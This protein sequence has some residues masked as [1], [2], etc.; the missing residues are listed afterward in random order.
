MQLKVPR[1]VWLCSFALAGLAVLLVAATSA[2]AN[3]H[4]KSAGKEL[5]VLLPHIAPTLDGDGPGSNDPG[6]W[7]MF[8]NVY[9]RLVGYPTQ[10]VGKVIVPNYK[11][12]PLQFAPELAQSY[13]K[14]GLNWTFHLRKGV[15][16]CAGNELTTDDVVYTFARGKSVSGTA[17]IAWFMLNVSGVMALDP[18]LPKAPAAAKLLKGEITKVDNYTFTVKQLGP[19][20]LFPRLLE[21][22]GM[23]IYDSKEIKKHAT[24]ADPWSHKF[25][26]NVGAAGFGP[27]CVTRWAKGSEFELTANPKWTPQPQFT[28]AIIRQVPV[29]SNRISAIRSGS[30]DIVT[31]LSPTEYQSLRSASNVDVLSRF[32][33]Q[34]VW[35]FMNYK[36]APWNLPKNALLRQAV[37]LAMPYNDI[38]AQDYKGRARRWNGALPST[39]YGYKPFALY[40]T[41]LA[42][43]KA[44]LAKA[45]FPGGKGLEKYSE[46]LKLLYPA[47]RSALSEPVAN[48][49]RTALAKIGIPITLNPIPQ[50]E[51]SD[52]ELTKRDMPM[53]LID[54]SAPFGPDIGY[55]AQLYFVSV[56]KGGLLNGSN[57]SN[58]TFDTDYYKSQQMTGAARLTALGKLQGILMNNLPIVPIAEF[59][60]QIVV[61]KGLTGWLATTDNGV[62]LY[63]FTAPN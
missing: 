39:Y 6:M 34:A 26:G 48:R 15:I 47:E 13:S 57:Y 36:Y 45:G 7:M 53:A 50:T 2:G 37:A 5:V 27:Y 11:I 44:L 32:N 56:A 33:N 21:I 43:A 4:A 31:D 54:Y 22:F 59:E 25:T 12:G 14:S 9:Q 46:G 28:R 23:G 10:R 62:A 16:S 60:S 38:I 1:R 58:A 52:R 3:G 63:P 55:G 40:N 61:R 8:R 18:V 49:I 42:K 24:A 29:S 41:D 17:P 30:A 20:E 19:N 35:V 51:V